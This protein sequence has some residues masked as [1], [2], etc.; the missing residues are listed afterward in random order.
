MIGS[1]TSGR[2]VSSADWAWLLI[3]AGLAAIPLLYPLW[4]DP[5]SLSVV[6]DALIFGLFALSLDFLWGKA[7]ILSFGH[8]AFF[9]VGAY[10]T[11]IVAPMVGGGSAGLIGCLF[12][13]ALAVGI[14]L[15]VGYFLIFGGVRGAYF[16]I[17]TLALSLVAQHI[18]IGWARVTGGDAGLIG[19]P[20][21]GIGFGGT[22]FVRADPVF[23]APDRVLGFVFLFTDLMERRA[24]EAARR[25]FQE[26]VIERHRVTVPLDSKADLVYR[27]LLASVIGNAQLAALEI[28][29]GVDLA[30]MPEMLESVRA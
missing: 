28:T 8:A 6:R 5:Y 2:P 16:T 22:S 4:T 23:S 17:V 11:A 19:T 25:R 9:G 18:V 20:P 7:G 24:A 1:A 14:A 30:R 12:G 10:G 26:R 13:I 21:P 3:A 27:N 15:I 29:D